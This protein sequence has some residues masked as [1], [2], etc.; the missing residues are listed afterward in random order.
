MVLFIAFQPTSQLVVIMWPTSG[1]WVKNISLLV[2]GVSKVLGKV[3]AFVLK[4][5]RS[6]QH[7]P[8]PFSH[9]QLG[10]DV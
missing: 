3:F 10:C 1:Q 6:I 8:S 7:R 4:K 2:G 9:L 5:N